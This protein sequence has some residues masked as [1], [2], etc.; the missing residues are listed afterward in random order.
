MVHRLIVAVLLV[1]GGQFAAQAQSQ[2]FPVFNSRGIQIGPGKY[3][4]VDFH[5]DTY[6]K[7]ARLAGNVM[8]RGGGG[9][10]IAVQVVKDG[11]V[12]YD[13]GQLRSIVLSIR[14]DEPG[15]YSLV[16]SNGFS[17]VSSKVVWG[18]VSLYSDGQ[19]LNRTSAELKKRQVRE[20]VARE[21]LSKL[22]ATLVKNER[23]WYT[24]QVS[25]M[26]TIVVTAEHDLNAFAEAGSNRIYVNL[27]LF[28]FAESLARNRSIADAKNLLAGVIGHELAHIFYF[29]IT[30]VTDRVDCGAS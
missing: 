29:T 3:F 26:P 19:D 24:R 6:L 20:D 16:L 13:S 14:L 23:Q 30:R 15:Q 8:A 25:V 28:E 7:R 22:Y 27:G 1:L 5:V 4:Y 12:I 21:I 11:R 17:V 9:N 10:D 18:K 2:E